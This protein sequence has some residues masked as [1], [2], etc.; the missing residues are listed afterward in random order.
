[1]TDFDAELAEIFSGYGRL[2][3]DEIQRRAVS[4]SAS[5]K[6]LG[7]ID[8]LPEGEY[9]YDEATDSL[10]QVSDHV[11]GTAN[12]GVAAAGLPDVDLLRELEVLHA[13]RHDTFLHGSARALTAHSDRTGELEAEYLSRYPYRE[14]DP[15]R[16][17]AGARGDLA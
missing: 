13:S 15:A 11:R 7:A 3:R 14:I 5:S 4:T 9:A 1:M 10:L 17:R 8:S 2:T 12:A 6:L 16:T